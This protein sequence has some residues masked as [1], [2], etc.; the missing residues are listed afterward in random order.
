ML[1]NFNLV[2][3]Y[4]HAAYQNQTTHN[5]QT[6][7][8]VL[9]ISLPRNVTATNTT[10]NINTQQIFYV[11]LT[12]KRIPDHSQPSQK[13]TFPRYTDSQTTRSTESAPHR[14]EHAAH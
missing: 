9:L 14:V 13:R 11:Y 1:Y 7:T 4:S 8:A 6:P 10:S 12:R 5:E 2:I 3:K